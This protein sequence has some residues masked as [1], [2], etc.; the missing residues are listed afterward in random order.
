MLVLI[1]INRKSQ[2]SHLDYNIFET[3]KKRQGKLSFGIFFLKKKSC[4]FL[5]L[6]MDIND[7]DDDGDDEIQLPDIFK[8]KKIF[9]MKI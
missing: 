8:K 9:N 7:N 1:E 5:C 2:L 3:K 4:C 6:A